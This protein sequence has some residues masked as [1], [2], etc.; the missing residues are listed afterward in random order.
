MGT[1]S[2]SVFCVV[3]VMANGKQILKDYS[4]VLEK[5]Q[6]MK[7]KSTFRKEKETQMIM[8]DD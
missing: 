6:N 8:I 7:D 3:P 1:L 4:K 2:S 5:V